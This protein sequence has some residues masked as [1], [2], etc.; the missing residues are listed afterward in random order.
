MTFGSSTSLL[1]TTQSRS[2]WAVTLAVWK[3]MFLRESLARLFG[4]RAAWVWALAEPAVHI[5]Y[6][7]VVM[8]AIRVTHIGGI[9][10][11][12]WIGIGF[13]AFFMFRRTGAEGMDAV[14]DNS[15]L[16]AYRQVK[17]VDG[18]LVRAGLEGFLMV[19]I[20]LL[21]AVAVALS[22][23]SVWPDDPLMVAQA[24][25]GLWLVGVGFGLVTSVIKEMVPELGKVIRFFLR[26]LYLLSGIMFPLSMVPLPYRE[27][28]MWNPV[29]HGIEAARKGFADYYH[30]VPEL[31]LSY[32]YAFALV[33]IFLGLA[34]HRRFQQRLSAL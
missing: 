8:G 12:L 22:G 19:V 1:P 4:S 17:P 34:L 13:L 9:H 14:G 32:L 25:A 2:A 24:F 26:P 33:S 21:V 23:I 16:F 7:M 31:S 5:G 15:A 11:T 18:V 10:T 29:A 6:M 27:W 28:L 30:A 20:G 3:A